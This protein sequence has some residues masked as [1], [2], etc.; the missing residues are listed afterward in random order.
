MRS[1]ILFVLL[2]TLLLS[3][4]SYEDTPNCH[5][6]V[7]IVNEF[8]NSIYVSHSFIYPDTVDFYTPFP[9][10]DTH[11]NKV[12]PNDKSDIPLFIGRDCWEV[13]IKDKELVSSDTLMI[14]VF[15]GELIENISWD[16]ISSEYKVLRRY[17]VSLE[18]LQ[19]LNWTITYP[20]TEA[21]RDVKMFPPYG[22]N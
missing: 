18:D 9:K 10:I 12:F 1:L 21:M 2:S 17:D 20:P 13:L 3:C 6:R 14:Y 4:R 19:R 5:R 7:M 8:E 16:I 22:T 15:D 11:L